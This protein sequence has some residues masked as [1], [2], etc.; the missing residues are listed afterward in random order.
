[1]D[2]TEMAAIRA[3]ELATFTDTAVRGVFAEGTPNDLGESVPSYTAGTATACLVLFT[4]GQERRSQ[5]IQPVLWDA[6]A[7]VPYDY[8]IAY[9][10]RLTLTHR[11]GV[12]LASSITFEVVGQPQ[13]GMGHVE[14]KLLLVTP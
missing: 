9:R 4:G 10:D 3:D 5:D 7:R 13:H 12:A 11:F 2:T 8:T 14:V 6:I 1:M